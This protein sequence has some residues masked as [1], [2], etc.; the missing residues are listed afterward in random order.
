MPPRQHQLLELLIAA[1]REGHSLAVLYLLDNGSNPFL[2]DPFR[3]D[4]ETALIAASKN[5]HADIVA[6][7]CFHSEWVSLRDEGISIKDNLGLDCVQWAIRLHHVNCLSV[8]LHVQP[9]LIGEIDQLAK[10]VDTPSTILSSPEFKSF[11]MMHYPQQIG[12]LRAASRN[13]V[14][15]RSANATL[16]QPTVWSFDRFVKSWCCSCASWYRLENSLVSYAPYACFISL[17]LGFCVSIVF[18]LSSEMW[19]P[20]SKMIPLHFLN[21]TSQVLLWRQIFLAN[22]IEA[23]AVYVSSLYDQNLQRI[24]ELARAGVKEAA[25]ATAEQS[26]SRIL[27]GDTTHVASDCCHICRTWKR[28]HVG[29]SPVTHRCIPDYDHYCVYLGQDIGRDNYPA[30]FFALGLMAVVVMPVFILLAVIF[31]RH[32]LVSQSSKSIASK[33]WRM[34]FGVFLGWS[35]LSEC[36]MLTFFCFHVYATSVGL[37]TR[38]VSKNRKNSS[39]LGFTWANWRRRMY[40]QLDITRTEDHAL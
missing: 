20:Y 22:K 21:F 7:C 25:A 23:G 14:Y 5:G 18:A 40:P 11:I 6:I 33:L 3:F 4:G 17:F 10:Q 8:F 35:G 1:C 37:T 28:D 26:N 16:R 2:N 31:V 34:S 36:Q 29:H 12:I 19:L 39:K 9:N 32:G 30:F 27:R 24:V 13:S 15:K 38:E